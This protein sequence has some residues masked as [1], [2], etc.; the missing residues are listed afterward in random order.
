MATAETKID[1]EMVRQLNLYEVL[2]VSAKASPE[3]VHAA[4]RALAREYHPD[5]NDTPQAARM[6]RQLNAA[7]RVLS[8]PQRR[9][10]YDA[11]RAHLW[12]VRSAANGVRSSVTSVTGSAPAT[13][14]TPSGRRIVQP[15]GYV[16]PVW[17]VGRL[18]ALV[19]V[20]MLTMGAMLFVFWLVATILDDDPQLMLRAVISLRQA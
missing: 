12:R 10:K 2:Q 14:T 16:K 7:Y 4:Y 6:M 8:D 20:L 3:V 17:R 9:A 13:V 18:A 1:R 19:L 15:S 5:V 11:Q